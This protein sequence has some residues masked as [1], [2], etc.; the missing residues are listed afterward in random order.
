MPWLFAGKRM[1][2]GH[3][4]R[5]QLAGLLHMCEQGGITNCYIHGLLRFHDCEPNEIA[6]TVPA[7]SSTIGRGLY[8]RLSS[9]ST[10]LVLR[11]VPHLRRGL[12][13][14]ELHLHASSGYTDHLYSQQL[15]AESPIRRGG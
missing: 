10:G 15:L 14:S 1:P 4:A 8:G 2:T 9:R 5:R 11:H 12:G 13:A 7:L 6:G 3:R